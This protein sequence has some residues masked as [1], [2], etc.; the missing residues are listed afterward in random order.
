MIKFTLI[1]AL[2]FFTVAKTLSN[3]TVA[4]SKPAINDLVLEVVQNMPSRGGYDVSREAFANLKK[5]ITVKNNNLEVMASGAHPSFCS[6]STYLVF[7]QVLAQLQKQGKLHLTEAD[8]Q[9]FT[10]GNPSE[11]PDGSG[12]WGRWNS[13]GPGTAR[14][15]EELQLG[16]NF[17]KIDEALPG[18]F[19]KIFWNDEIGAK[20]KGHSVIFMG[21]R[22]EP[23]GRKICYWSSNQAYEGEPAGGMGVK[24]SDEKK[25]H[26]TLFSRLE[27]P[28]A[29]EKSLASISSVSKKYTDPYLS[30]LLKVASSPKEMCDKV[31]CVK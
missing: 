4:E 12:V 11:Q 23:S 9:N 14:L 20:E 10:V 5:S 16:R 29:L 27:N 18:D 3:H 22:V 2:G 25:I 28:R 15:F 7:T 24:C 26:R 19:M 1:C 8:W 17:T 30:S 6:E 13:N 31:N 21:V